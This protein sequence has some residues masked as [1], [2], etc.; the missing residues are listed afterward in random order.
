MAKA[1]APKVK[2]RRA[3]VKTNKIA[4][5]ARAIHVEDG[6]GSNVVVLD[7]L[8]VL[9]TKEDGAWMARGIQIDYACDGAT[10]P[11]VKA[12]F[13]EGLARSVHSNIRTSG[14]FVSLLRYAPKETIEAY[15][16]RDHTLRRFVH[17][18]VTRHQL[19]QALP[20]EKITWIEQREARRA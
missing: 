13:A 12:N 15:L 19:Q 18:Q 8:D 4:G 14:N 17:S 3:V 2:R 16:H 1:K 6:D 7:N 5:R 20:L 9:I 10:I 11:Q